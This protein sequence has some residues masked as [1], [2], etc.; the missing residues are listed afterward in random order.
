MKSLLLLAALTATSAMAQE[1]S[2]KIKKPADPA[3]KDK[4]DQVITNRRL[5]ADSGSLSK[6]SLN[7]KW[8]YNAGSVEKPVDPVRPNIT[9]AADAV[10]L[11]RLTG[12]VGLRYRINTLNSVS[13]RAGVSM[14]TPFH[15]S[16]DTND[17]GVQRQF[18]DNGGD[19][20]IND[21][22]LA[23]T[24]LFKLAG[25]QNVTSFYATAIT[26]DFLSDLGY[27]Y[28]GEIAHQLIYDMGKSGFSVGALV[29][30]Q[31]YFFSTEDLNG[32]NIKSAQADYNFGLYPMAEYVI[33]DTFN[34]RTISGVWVYEHNKTDEA[35]TYRKRKIYQSVGLGISVSRDVFLYP[36][37]QFLPEKVR[38]DRTNVGFS[39]NINI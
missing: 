10:T 25:I 7:T 32:S 36:N 35:Y 21:P 4:A 29:R 34:L 5:R 18:D 26:Q 13:L 31:K 24:T 17:Q 2:T 8:S 19:L 27:E 30:G 12:D 11:Q 33:N 22:Q 39:A 38:A 20:N 37:I 6:W 15:T 1:I 3:G 14:L 28:S 23:Y 9:G 16:I